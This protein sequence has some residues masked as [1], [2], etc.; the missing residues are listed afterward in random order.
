MDGLK[1]LIQI[2]PVKRRAQD[3]VS[4]YDPP[5]GE[6]QDWNVQTPLQFKYNLIYV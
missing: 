1:R 4:G 5:P 3:S 2:L 6:F